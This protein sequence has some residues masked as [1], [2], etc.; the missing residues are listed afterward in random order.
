M[1]INEITCMKFRFFLVRKYLL[2]TKKGVFKAFQIEVE[3]PTGKV[4]HQYFVHVPNPGPQQILV[5]AL[6]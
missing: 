4:Y 6:S 1:E 5:Q 2:A 3:Y